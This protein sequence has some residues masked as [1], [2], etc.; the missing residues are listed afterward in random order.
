MSEM[1]NTYPLNHPQ[2]LIPVDRAT[3]YADHIQTVLKT[4]KP[5]A[6]IEI[7]QVFIFNERGE[8]ICQKRSKNKKHNPN[9]IDKSLGGHIVTGDSAHHTAMIETVQ[10]LLTP[11][12]VLNDRI[13]FLKTHE[14]LKAYLNTIALLQFIQTE[15]AV[16]DNHFPE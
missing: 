11:S 7:V 13:D 10:E 5:E 14:T 6:F 2:Q 3:F 8:L 4:G 9:L 16:I 1:I 12:I 15:D